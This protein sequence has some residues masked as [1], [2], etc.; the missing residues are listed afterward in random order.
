MDSMDSTIAIAN[1]LSY[2]KEF[3]KMFLMLRKPAYA[4]A[5]VR[6][7]L[8]TCMLRASYKIF[9]H[10]VSTDNEHWLSHTKFLIHTGCGWMTH[11]SEYE[12]I[13][14]EK[15]RTKYAVKFVHLKLSLGENRAVKFTDLPYTWTWLISD[16]TVLNNRKEVIVENKSK[17]RN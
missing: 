11:R 15:L 7:R 8:R 1:V 5:S 17:M 14:C 4:I 2:R 9:R 6:G 3:S 16:L 13:P 12:V 10:F